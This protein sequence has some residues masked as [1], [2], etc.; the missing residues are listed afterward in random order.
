MSIFSED[1]LDELHDKSINMDVVDFI[2]TTYGISFPNAIQDLAAYLN[3][4]PKYVGE[5]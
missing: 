2:M 1:F 4:E 5:K 3:I